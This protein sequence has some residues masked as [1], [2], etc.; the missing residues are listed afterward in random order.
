MALVVSANA[1]LET[2]KLE[3]PTGSSAEVSLFGAH[4]LS[5]RAATAPKHDIMFMSNKNNYDSKRT[6]RGG[7][8][9]LFPNVSNHG[10]TDDGFASKSIW[11]LDH[12]EMPTD[13]E[14]PCV[15]TFVLKSSDA[16]RKLWPHDFILTYEVILA[17]NQ[18]ETALYVEVMSS[19]MVN[20]QVLFHNYLSVDDVHNNGVQVRELEGIQYNDRIKKTTLQ[21]INHTSTC[22][23]QARHNCRHCDIALLI[24]Y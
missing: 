1:E 15:A 7:I 23:T 17:A 13:N 3:H 14:S 11:T 19:E 12:T 24:S 22:H 16:T 2:V 10:G 21:Y 20:F 6:I 18:L 9:I 5:F 4:V 8:P